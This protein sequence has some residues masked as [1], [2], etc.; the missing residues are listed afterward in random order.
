MFCVLHCSD[1]ETWFRPWCFNTHKVVETILLVE[2]QV[3]WCWC[4]GERV[5]SNISTCLSALPFFFVEWSVTKS[6]E[7][8]QV[9]PVTPLSTDVCFWGHVSHPVLLQLANA[10][11]NVLLLHAS[12]N[13][14]GV[15]F[16]FMIS[17]FMTKQQNVI[18]LNKQPHTFQAESAIHRI[19]NPL[20]WKWFTDNRKNTNPGVRP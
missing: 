14:A 8:W 5:K 17:L 3:N 12:R 11:T 15:S 4:V 18:S 6:V 20:K 9:I 16:H 19:N 10:N 7:I 2:Y 1:L 13:V